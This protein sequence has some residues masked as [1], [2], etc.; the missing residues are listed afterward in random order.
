[1]FLKG[2][3]MNQYKDYSKTQAIRDPNSLAR[4]LDWKRRYFRQRIFER[5]PTDKG[6]RILDLG[7]GYGV[8]VDELRKNG[9][10]KT[11]GVDISE[12]QIQNARS[13]FGLDCVRCINAMDYL[14]EKKESYDCILALDVLEH[15]TYD[16]LITITK[17]AFES[18]RDG[19]RLIAQAP[20]GY[21]LLNSIIYADLT[22]VR[23]FTAQSFEQ[24]FLLG[25]F[26][27]ASSFFEALPPSDNI[28]GAVKMLIWRYG[29]RPMLSLYSVVAAG[30]TTARLFSQ[31]II[32]V[33]EK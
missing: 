4:L 7:C 12:D 21:S 28:V 24:L 6:I 31:N 23:A 22:H 16:D 20:N 2:H 19:G 1:V 27:K 15:L 11:E 10:D 30:K 3:L 5:I 17:L 8:F 18:L 32:A 13:L 29:I 25:G 33:V 26:T 9:Y 14:E